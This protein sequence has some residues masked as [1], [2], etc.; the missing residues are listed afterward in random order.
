MYDLS[1]AMVVGWGVLLLW[2]AA[3]CE[4]SALQA[5]ASVDTAAASSEYAP[6]DGVETPFVPEASH[7]R[8]FHVL[9][10]RIR[11]HHAGPR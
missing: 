6:Q 11:H 10:R 9:A 7:A 8:R 4:R 5:S 1:K 2:M 3:G